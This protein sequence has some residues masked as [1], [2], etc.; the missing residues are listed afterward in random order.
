MLGEKRKQG[1]LRRRLDDIMSLQESIHQERV[2][3]SRCTE[4]DFCRAWASAMPA[5]C[6]LGLVLLK[7]LFSWHGFSQLKFMLMIS[8]RTFLMLN[9]HVPLLWLPVPPSWFSSFLCMARHHQSSLCHPECP[10][11]SILGHS[12]FTF[13]CVNMLEMHFN[14]N[15]NE[16]P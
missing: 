14:F 5:F 3:L 16:L 2:G 15:V 11:R 12:L 1:V 7:K 13:P 9:N 4:R 6:V 8:A 10:P